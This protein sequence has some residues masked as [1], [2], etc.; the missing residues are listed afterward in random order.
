MYKNAGVWAGSFFLA[1]SLIFG[2]TSFQYDYISKDQGI[3]PGPGFFPFWLCLFMGVCSIIYIF[4]SIRKPV[5]ARSI[6]PDIRG[7]K[8][9]GRI[10]FC[11]I[12][13]LL[14][15]RVAGFIITFMLMLSIFFYGYFR[16]PVNLLVSL[17]GAL[18]LYA[19]FIIWLGVPLP[20]ND[21]GW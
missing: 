12:M 1:I 20:V 17:G 9:I 6:L 5:S 16:L 10:L 8:A 18:F 3:G 15:A 21:F 2:V 13:Y 11:I 19:V 4:T 7:M 14:I